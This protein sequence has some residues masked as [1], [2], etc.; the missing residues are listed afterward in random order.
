MGKKLIEK[1]R[2]SKILKDLDEESIETIEL[3][4][5]S[6]NN[7]KDKICN[8]IIEETTNDC[9]EEMENLFK[10]YIKYH[11]NM[12]NMISNELINLQQK[13]SK[14][15]TADEDIEKAKK[16]FIKAEE[17][18]KY[19]LP[20]NLKELR[21]KKDEYSIRSANRGTQLSMMNKRMK[22]KMLSLSYKLV[23]FG[24]QLYSIFEEELNSTLIEELNSFLKL[25]IEVAEKIQIENSYNI[26]N[27][28]EKIIFKDV[29]K[30]PIKYKLPTT[31]SELIKLAEENGFYFCRQGKTS[32]AIYKNN[33]NK[34]IVIP[35]KGKSTVPIGTQ[36]QILKRIFMN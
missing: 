10:P 22:I 7:Y 23:N 9:F 29:K 6:S 35:N 28:Y 11:K 2:N 16:V 26:E 24:I 12:Q 36:F 1:I 33:N 27:I 18:F 32:H 20:R 21:K 8:K 17:Y 30:I 14:R 4:L 25:E 34:I 13:N 31:Y 3:I 19:I 15:I 5:N